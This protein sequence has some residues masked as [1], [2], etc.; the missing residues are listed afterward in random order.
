[1]DGWVKDVLAIGLPAISAAGGV[2]GGMRLAVRRAARWEQHVDDSLK[3]HGERLQNGTASV[4]EVPVLI[5]RLE[6]TAKDVLEIKED[7]KEI[8][9]NMVTRAECDRTHKR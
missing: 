9:S 4:K 8:R 3:V 6:G 7:V 2:Y 1:M 5:A